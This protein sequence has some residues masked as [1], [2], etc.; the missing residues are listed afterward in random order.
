MTATCVYCGT[1]PEVETIEQAHEH[2]AS[3]TH[4]AMVELRYDLDTSTYE[5]P[6]PTI[7]PR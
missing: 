5:P 3:E 4:R 2:V 7:A 1:V 6:P